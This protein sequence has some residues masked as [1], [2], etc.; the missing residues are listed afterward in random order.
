MWS[1]NLKSKHNI[2][3]CKTK[4]TQLKQLQPNIWAL[5]VLFTSVLYVWHKLECQAALKMETQHRWAHDK[6]QAS[7]YVRG[8]WRSGFVHIKRQTYQVSVWW[9]Y[10]NNKRCCTSQTGH[11]VLLQLMTDDYSPIFCKVLFVRFGAGGW[12]GR[13]WW[14]AAWE[15][16]LGEGD[17]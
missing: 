6:I 14:S 4:Y 1:T 13:W 15:A 17:G 16:A 5:K 3:D 11:P 10:N 8:V 9:F 7:E 12:L 2:E